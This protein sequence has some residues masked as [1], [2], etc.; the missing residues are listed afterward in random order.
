MSRTETVIGDLNLNR[1][2]E[3]QHGFQRCRDFQ[4]SNIFRCIALRR[5]IGL[6]DDI[7]VNQMK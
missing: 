3:S 5:D 6:I 4:L 1:S 2:I 7:E